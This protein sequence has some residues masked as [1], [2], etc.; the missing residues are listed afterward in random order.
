M[1]PPDKETPRPGTRGAAQKRTF[2]TSES[3]NVIP[4]RRHP[5]PPPTISELIE[6]GRRRHRQCV[7]CGGPLIQAPAWWRVCRECFCWD[8]LARRHGVGGAV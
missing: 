1:R 7:A 2:V 6:A 8:R 3:S 5:R 4:L